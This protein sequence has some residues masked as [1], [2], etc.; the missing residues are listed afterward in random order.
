MKDALEVP[1][2]PHKVG[3]TGQEVPV[4]LSDHVVPLACSRCVECQPGPGVKEECEEKGEG[5]RYEK[6]KIKSSI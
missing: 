2:G 5:K 1:G 3:V 4:C 6:D